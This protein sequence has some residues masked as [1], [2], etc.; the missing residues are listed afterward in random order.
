MLFLL[1]L[2]VDLV[3]NAAAMTAVDDAET[4]KET[5]ENSNHYGVENLAIFCSKHAI[6]LIHFS[7]DYVFDGEE[8]TPYVESH[9]PNPINVYG[10]SKLDGERVIQTHCSH[11]L[12]FRIQSLFGSKGKNFITTILN[13]AESNDQLSIISDQW[14]SPTWSRDVAGM[15]AKLLTHMETAATLPFGSISTGIYHYTSSEFSN[16]ANVARFILATQKHLTLSNIPSIKNIPSSAYPQAAKRP[17]FS[18]L[19]CDKFDRL[20]LCKRPSW[21][22]AIRSFLRDEFG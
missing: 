19:N 8:N 10:Q 7:T 14:M 6:P 17:S 9:D 13:L 11:F 12:I 1:F 5:A 4:Q 21:K 2:P 15:I 3:I 22:D 18:V 16:W 20:R